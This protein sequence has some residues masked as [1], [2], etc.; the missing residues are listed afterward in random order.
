MPLPVKATQWPKPVTFPRALRDAIPTEPTMAGRVLH[1][2][3]IDASPSHTDRGPRVQLR[4]MTEESGKLTGR[5]SA[6]LLAATPIEMAQ[7]SEQLE[8]GPGW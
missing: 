5:F 3:G 2:S 4:V 6:R 8:P 7:R 1:L